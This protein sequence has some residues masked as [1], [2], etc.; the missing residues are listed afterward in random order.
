MLFP[1]WVRPRRTTRSGCS[2]EGMVVDAR[3]RLVAIVST[4]AYTVDSAPWRLSSARLLQL[5]WISRSNET[6]SERAS[7]RRASGAI[8]WLNGFPNRRS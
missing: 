1:A 5:R 3:S 2:G 4:F 6:I 7:K 8:A